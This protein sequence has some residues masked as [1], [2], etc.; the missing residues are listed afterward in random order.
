MKK[1]MSHGTV[2]RFVGQAEN[3]LKSQIFGDLE[4][5][6]GLALQKGG[7]AHPGCNYGAHQIVVHTY[8]FLSSHLF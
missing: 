7:Q 2:L 3:D 1:N 8:V 4:S 6:Q 5:D